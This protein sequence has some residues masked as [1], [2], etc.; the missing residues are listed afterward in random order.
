MTQGVIKISQLPIAS[1]PLTG[2][3]LAVVVQNNVTKKT[4]VANLSAGTINVRAYGAT[5]DGATDDTA[6]IAAALL[7]GAGKAVYFPATD[8]YYKIT[9]ELTIPESTHLIGDGYNSRIRQITVEKNAFL[10]G[11]YSVV[12]GLRISGDGVARN[13]VAFTKNNGIFAGNDAAANA[14]INFKVL[15]CWIDGWQSCGIQM[16]NCSNYEIDGC[17]FFNNYWTYPSGQTNASDICAYSLVDGSRAIISNNFC[18]SDNS[19]GIYFNATGHDT[20]ATIANNVCVTLD[21]NWQEISLVASLNRR[22]G[23]VATYLGGSGGRVSCAGNVCRNTLVSGIYVTSGVTG[24]RPIVVANNVCSYNGRTTDPADATLGGGISVN[25]GLAGLVISNN[26]ISDFQGTAASDVGGITYNDQN[27]DSAASALIDGNT[28]TTSAGYGIIAKNSPKNVVISNNTVRGSTS[29]DIYVVATPG[30]NTKNIRILNNQIIRTSVG[31]GIRLDADAVT[32]RFWIEGNYVKGFNSSTAS[33]DNS[34]I[35]F[36]RTDTGYATIR[37]N[38]IETCRYGIIGEQAVAGREVTRLRVDFNELNDC[39]EGIALRG[40]TAAS[41]VPCLGNR[42]TASVL[43]KFGGA[44]FDVAGF[45]VSAIMDDTRIY[46]ETTASP[47]TRPFIRGDI[48]FNK[49]P[50]VGGTRGWICASSGTPGTWDTLG[51]TAFSQ[52]SD[53]NAPTPNEGN[54]L[55]YDATTSKWVNTGTINFDDGAGEFYQQ[56]G[57]WGDDTTFIGKL[58]Y[59]GTGLYAG[60]SSNHPFFLLAG[61]TTR[62]TVG[63][64]GNIVI[65][66]AA[67]ATTATSGFPWIPSCPGTPTGAPTAPYTNAAAMVVDTSNNRLYVLVGG[68]WKYAT[69][70]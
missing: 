64:N 47:T 69:L 5:G 45:E 41:L 54:M 19:Q 56:V 32:E 58:T 9:D 11:S 21:S 51:P 37:Y 28:I 35:F 55:Y 16:R 7:A 57:T 53:V 10:M 24:T 67:L 14:C 66:G 52:L 17:V 31:S 39:F 23:I 65:G 62:M 3:E 46:F 22:H 70:T 36:R 63:D 1:I 12:E 33:V 15:N 44:G 40:T 8:N 18:L 34:G 26:V 61:N 4:A 25:G 6:A 20:D 50:T 38:K 43:T 30:T 29:Y 13:P 2:S 27:L 48:A 49:E 60:S 42:F 68:T 59:D